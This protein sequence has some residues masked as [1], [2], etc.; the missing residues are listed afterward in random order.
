MYFNLEL[1]SK[2]EGHVLI[3]ISL[4]LIGIRYFFHDQKIHSTKYSFIHI[5]FLMVFS[6][7]A[8]E[9]IIVMIAFYFY[10][11]LIDVAVLSPTFITNYIFIP[12][13]IF[14]SSLCYFIYWVLKY[15]QNL[16]DD[17][18]KS[19]FDQF[20]NNTLL[21]NFIK[22]EQF[23]PEYLSKEILFRNIVIW[24]GYPT[25]SDD[26]ERDIIIG[27]YTIRKPLHV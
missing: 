16:N 4:G 10:N 18:S 27:E 15:F 17:R 22:S 2:I 26:A 21:L 1:I 20:D 6:I 9:F 3:M 13:L 12:K 23:K 11:D 19:E 8:I 25:G 7:F 5:L 24:K 14:Y